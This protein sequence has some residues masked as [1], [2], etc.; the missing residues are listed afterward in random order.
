MREDRGW[1]GRRGEEGKEERKREERREILS[2]ALRCAK[3]KPG[4]LYWK[5]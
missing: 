1:E 4:A 3:E 5:F 2:L